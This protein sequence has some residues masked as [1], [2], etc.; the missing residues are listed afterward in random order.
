M[1]EVFIKNGV[2]NI[3]CERARSSVAERS[4]HNR[5]VVGSKP[6]E[7]TIYFHLNYLLNATNSDMLAFLSSLRVFGRL[8]TIGLKLEI[9]RAHF[10]TI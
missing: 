9:C 3:L 7:P 5:L 10:I 8:I 6:T 4:A 1:Q 2:C